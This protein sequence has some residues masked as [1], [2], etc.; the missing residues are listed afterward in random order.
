MLWD[1]LYLMKDLCWC[2]SIHYNFD[3]EITTAKRSNIIWYI[4]C[5]ILTQQDLSEDKQ[6]QSICDLT[7]L[8]TLSWYRVMLARFTKLE[9]P[10]NKIRKKLSYAYTQKFI[11]SIAQTY[12][13]YDWNSWE[14]NLCRKSCRATC[15]KI[16]LHCEKKNLHNST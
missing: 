15:S 8:R 7:C 1:N 6:N 14:L 10:M 16:E 11:T 3:T 9:L 5:T 12:T 2:K 13:S 4:K